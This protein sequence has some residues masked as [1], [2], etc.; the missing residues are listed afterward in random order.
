MTTPTQKDILLDRV[1]LGLGV[2]AIVLLAGGLLLRNLPVARTLPASVPQGVYVAGLVAMA[3]Y[4][5]SLAWLKRADLLSFGK[6]RHARS[7]ANLGVQIA[8]VLAILA[9]VNWF[10]AR[11]HGK[12]DLT[13]NKQYSLSEQ[14]QKIVK[15]LQEP[16][17]ATVFVKTGDP[18]SENLKTLWKDYA[19]LNPDKLKLDV[20]D[21]DKDPTKARQMEITMINSSVLQRGSR[22]T[23]ITGTQEQDLTSGLLKVT[24][25]GQKVVYFVT[26]HGEAA[27][28][29]F[30]PA[31]LSY[32]K[33][34]LEKQNYKVDTLTLFGKAPAVPADAAV[35]VI[36]GPDKP[37]QPAEIAAL[38]AYLDKGGKLYAALRPIKDA[39]LS[40]LLADYGIVVRDDLVVDLRMNA[41][42]LDA[43]AVKQF[44]YHQTTQNLQVAYF[45]GAR[46]LQKADKLPGGV[47]VTPLV[48]T[49]DEAWGETSYRNPQLG[50]D[51]KADHKG[52]L[53]L[54]FLAERGGTKVIVS[55]NASFIQNEH[56]V[57]YNDGDLF[58]N[59]LNYLADQENLVSIPP[60]DSTPKNVDLLPEQANGIFFGTV[61]GIPL[62][63]LLLGGF[64]WW[65]R[66]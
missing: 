32:A 51:P 9:A 14:T 64:V 7:G 59:G 16:V 4:L 13:Q 23:T 19:D 45:P 24:Q 40:G 56:Y 55:G 12:L 44:P 2:V 66:R 48:Q 49:G 8:A 53:D 18:G 25:S 41:G 35:V 36:V 52:P 62:A 38:K 10:G 43:P 65:R 37:Y 47:A 3:L 58:L 21:L 29:K 61:L 30:D 46:S 42:A 6:N 39:G 20:V 57:R 1:N 22:K 26:G 15:G 60:K 5:L 54:M 17:S 27:L 63:L 28:D 11:H 34:A 33:D 50:F 31:G